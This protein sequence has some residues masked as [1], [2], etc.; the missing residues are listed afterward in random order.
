METWFPFETQS[1]LILF[2]LSCFRGNKEDDTNLQVNISCNYD[3][4]ILP[5]GA[6]LIF[7]D[8]GLTLQSTTD[9]VY[10]TGFQFPQTDLRDTDIFNE[11][12]VYYMLEKAVKN[13]IREY[14]DNCEEYD[15][16]ATEFVVSPE[17]IQ[18]F[19][20][21][22]INQ[23]FDYRKQNDNDNINLINNIG[24]LCNP[25]DDTR[26]IFLGTF[27]VVD[28][29]L[30]S[31]SGYDSAFNRE[32]FNDIVPLPKYNT[33]NAICTQIETAPIQLTILEN[34]LFLKCLDC[35]MQV[36]LSDKADK[37]LS[38]LARYGLTA[39]VQKVFFKLGT[40]YFQNCKDALA[41]SNVRILDLEKS[42]DWAS[43][44]K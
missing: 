37:M 7:F 21:T 31:H 40:E 3:Y 34:I 29:L 5:N 11:R 13:C 44:F 15:V 23:Y 2:E 16:K 6:W 36:L 43:L 32:A 35:A 9:T 24:V 17:I 14:K 30:Y 33:L 26:I 39:E 10:R 42:H 12:I 1:A 18:P 38:Y 8:I 19:V 27:L 20:D 22:T 4:K 28:E 25:E 41:Q